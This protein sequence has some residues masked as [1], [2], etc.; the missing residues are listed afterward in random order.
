MEVIHDDLTQIEDGLHEIDRFVHHDDTDLSH[1]APYQ[2]LT[3]ED[4]RFEVQ[5]HH[6][7]EI[8]LLVHNELNVPVHPDAHHHF[9][10]HCIVHEL[11]DVLLE[12]ILSPGLK[13]G[14]ESDVWL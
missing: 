4:S 9:P 3:E 14:A 13:L 2:F 11:E 8:C 12:I 6:P 5:L 7:L 10:E 1:Q